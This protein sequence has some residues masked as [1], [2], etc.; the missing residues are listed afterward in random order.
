MCG[1]NFKKGWAPSQT[2]NTAFGVRETNGRTIIDITLKIDAPFSTAVLRIQFYDGVIFYRAQQHGQA[3]ILDSGTLTQSQMSALA[4]L[5]EDTLFLRMKNHP[6]NADD[7]L[8]GSTYT[9]AI[10]TLW[11]GADPA[12]AFPGVHSVSCYQFSCEDNFLRLKDKMIE[13]WGKDIL[14]IGV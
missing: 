1:K 7:P 12:L 3:E 4:K 14:E 6:Q 2:Q 5:L 9:I 10:R 11:P 8:D 13:L